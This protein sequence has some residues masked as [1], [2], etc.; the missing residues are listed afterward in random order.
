MPQ[1]IF[2]FS[3][4]LIETKDLDPSYVM[5]YEAKSQIPQDKLLKWLLS[6]LCFYHCGTAS[7]IV[8]QPDYWVAMEQ[9][10]G[11][12]NWPRGTE[13]RH[14]RGNSSLESIRWLKNNGG[15]E[16]L[17]GEQI[18]GKDWTLPDLMAQVKTWH[19][20]GDWIAFKVADLFERIGLIKVEFKPQDVFRMFES[21]KKGALEISK[22]LGGPKTGDICT[23]AQNKLLEKLGYLKAPPRYERTINIQECE[24]CMCKFHS[25]IHGKYNVGKDLREIKH[26]LEFAKCK[27][28][29]LLQEAGRKTGLW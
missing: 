24:T 19:V 14:Y 16:K 23:W 29:R 1:D 4:Q 28:S 11:S 22:R 13:R 27:T 6:Y 5:L 12:K 9:A 2:E 10:A 26:G 21:P 15:P 3:R 8:D 7:L 25:H 18:L 17:I 20:F